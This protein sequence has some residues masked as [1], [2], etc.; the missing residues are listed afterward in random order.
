MK[1]NNK[2]YILRHG[3]ALSNARNIVSCWPEKFKNPLTLEG[4]KMAED[5]A[6]KLKNKKIDLI[7]TSP[8]LRAKETAEIV[9][10]ALKIKIRIDKRLKEIC[11]GI[12]NSKAS[13]EF[14]ECFEN[15]EERINNG[16]PRGESYKD[17][18]ERMIDFLKTTERKYKKKNILIVSHQAPLFLLEGYIKDFSLSE[19]V[20]IILGEKMLKTGESKNLN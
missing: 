10:K 14:E 12:F 7:F 3:E 6:K 11:F 17:V 9:N 2:Y 5:A 1:L 19:T 20:K 8:L 16:A 18:L 4:R 13:A 15:T